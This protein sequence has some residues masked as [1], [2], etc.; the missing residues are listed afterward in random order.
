M[1]ADPILGESLD[2]VRST[3]S[4]VKWRRYDPDVLPM[5]VAEM[6]ARPC[7]VV[8]DAVT[9]AVAR[10]DTGY[11]WAPPYAEAMAG[12]ARRRWDWEIDPST[13]FTVVDV[14]VG[15]AELLRLATEPGGPVVVSTPCYNAFFGFLDHLGRTPVAAPL[16]TAGRLDLDEL[17]RAFSAVAGSRAAYLLCNPHNPTGTVPT[18]E[19]LTVVAELARRHQVTVISDEIHAP[20]VHPGGV[21]TPYLT[22]PGSETAVTVLSASKAWNVAALKCALVAP[23]EA[24]RPLVSGL[25]EVLTHAV[26]HLGLIGQAAA[27]TEGEPWLD[28]LVGELASNAVTLRSLL[29]EAL[30]EVS[31]AAPE[32]TFFAWLDCRRL[33]EDPAGVFLERGRVALTPGEEYAGDP[34]FARLNFATSPRVLAEGVRRMAAAVAGGGPGDLDPVTM[35]G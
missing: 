30:P 3:R 15:V 27:L 17:D 25:H 21:F 33:G 31:F 10:G 20:L 19:E 8:V 1:T 29:A 18:R 11:G 22:V 4:S 14:M 16:T 24:A 23:G 7:P 28:Q 35:K 32:A 2:R 13:T 6:D 5:W 26:S 12:F 34:G 9:A